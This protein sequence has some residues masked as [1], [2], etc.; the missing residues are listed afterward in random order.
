[1]PKPHTQYKSISLDYLLARFYIDATDSTLRWKTDVR[2]GSWRKAGS[3]VGEVANNGYYRVGLKLPGETRQ[4]HPNRA[5]FTVHRLMYQIYHSLD[6]LPSDTIIDHVNR[7]KT[8]NRKENLRTATKSENNCNV[9]LRKDN[10]S[11]ERGVTRGTKAQHRN[12]NLWYVA[13]QRSNVRYS[14]NFDRYEDAVAY[15][16][17]LR[18]ELH[19]KF[20]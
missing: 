1:M 13:V 10:T 3:I 14:G 9:K 19:G 18:K 6:S 16:R 20:A 11:G 2:G 4:T 8:D 7:V 15:A 12:P 17:S 5:V